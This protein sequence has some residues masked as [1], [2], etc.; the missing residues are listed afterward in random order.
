M[1][2]TQSNIY[3]INVLIVLCDNN[4]KPGRLAEQK[5]ENHQKHTLG[6]DNGAQR[7]QIY[8]TIY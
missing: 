8:K 7:G 2:N 3:K 1:T 6:E 5:R 4:N